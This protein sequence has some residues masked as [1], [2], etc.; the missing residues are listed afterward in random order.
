MVK[1][2]YIQSLFLI[3]LMVIVTTFY[4]TKENV[5]TESICNVCEKEFKTDESTESFLE[6]DLV[7]VTGDN[8]NNFEHRSD[9]NENEKVKNVCHPCATIL[10][11]AMNKVLSGAKILVLEQDNAEAIR[12]IQTES[13]HVGMQMNPATKETNDNKGRIPEEARKKEPS[14][15]IESE[16]IKGL[17]PPYWTDKEKMVY[18]DY[19]R[20]PKTF[21]ERK[22]KSV[23]I[24]LSHNNKLVKGKF[25]C[26]Q[27]GCEA[28]TTYCIMD[29]KG[30]RDY[31][32]RSFTCSFHL[33]SLTTT[34]KKPSTIRLKNAAPVK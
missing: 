18:R 34:L 32:E 13:L 10:Y 21:K 17:I 23:T 22:A 2:D 6:Y 31:D 5:M 26:F 14:K 16:K 24:S 12:K 9:K 27:K 30:E 29:G 28:E 3:C 8:E 20:E 4:L 7:L 25:P 11:A 1:N 33:Q 15:P 19:V